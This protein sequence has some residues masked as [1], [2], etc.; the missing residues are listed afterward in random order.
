MDRKLVIREKA[1]KFLL[2]LDHS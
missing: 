2:C 1:G